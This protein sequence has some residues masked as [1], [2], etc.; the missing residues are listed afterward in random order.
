M[1]CRLH[2]WMISKAHD[3]HRPPGRWTRRH[4]LH[5][6]SCRRYARQVE[7]LAA[8]LAADEA[9]SFA[10]DCEPSGQRGGRW[11]LAGAGLLA[12]ASIAIVVTLALRQ[13]EPVDSTADTAA[14]EPLFKAPE[15]AGELASLAGAAS[16][17]SYRTQ[18]AA[19]GEDAQSLLDMAIAPLPTS[20]AE[21]R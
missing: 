19:L 3:T 9:V 20:W 16:D 5:C 12:A 7:A 4:L 6:A 18:L 11:K 14:L 15:T 10:L 21:T 1:L 17:A 13:H 8:A 2:Q